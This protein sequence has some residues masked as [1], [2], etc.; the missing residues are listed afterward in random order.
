MRV[1]LIPVFHRLHRRFALERGL[2]QLVVVQ[3][4]IALQGLLHV[5]A[6]VESV[7]LQNVRN[8]AIKPF[9]HAV[10]S[11]SP[12]LGQPVLYAQ[13]LAQLVKLMVAA[14]FA[15]AAGKQAVCELFAVISQQFVDFDRTGLVQCLKEGLRWP[16]S[17]W[18]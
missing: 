18:P 14:G 15:F 6:A 7:G 11:W 5:L 3:S 2:R 10:G 13:L 1:R 17:C 4:H 9:H 16:P 12:G 8:A